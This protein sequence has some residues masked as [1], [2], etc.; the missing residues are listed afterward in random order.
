MYTFPL[1]VFAVLSGVLLPYLPVALKKV[2]IFKRQKEKFCSWQEVRRETEKKKNL[3]GTARLL[4]SSPFTSKSHT[5]HDIARLHLNKNDPGLLPH[6]AFTRGQLRKR[7]YR[8][9]HGVYHFEK[10]GR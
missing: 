8:R 2:Q 10:S 1:H 7:I 3:S 9:V 5:P 6:E 4:H